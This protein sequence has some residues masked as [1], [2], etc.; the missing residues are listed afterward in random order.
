MT[1]SFISALVTVKINHLS[2]LNIINK[3]I[4]NNL[5]VTHF[6]KLFLVLNKVI[7]L[8]ERNI[9]IKLINKYGKIYWN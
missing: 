4:L 5:L 9:K 8:F 7:I 3:N 1:I 6:N 2:I